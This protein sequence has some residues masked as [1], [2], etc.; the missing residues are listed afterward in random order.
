MYVT[1]I[2]LHVVLDNGMW[3]CFVKIF[4][5]EGVRG[6]YKGLAACYLKVIPSMAIS[7]MTFERCRVILQFEPVK[8]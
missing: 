2:S 5:Q 6:L 3:D 1:I 7:F 8:K 4:K